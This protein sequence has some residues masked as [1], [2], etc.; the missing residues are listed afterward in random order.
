MSDQSFF[1][2]QH[3]WLSFVPFAALLL[4]NNRSEPTILEGEGKMQPLPLWYT[5]YVCVSITLEAERELNISILDGVFVYVQF[6]I[7]TSFHPSLNDAMTTRNNLCFHVHIFH[8]KIKA[9]WWISQY[10]LFPTAHLWEITSFIFNTW[11]I[12]ESSVFKAK[13]NIAL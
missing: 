2:R 4:L 10:Y 12:G 11:K 6:T 3:C 13:L 7:K 9:H 1:N 5:Y 8:Y